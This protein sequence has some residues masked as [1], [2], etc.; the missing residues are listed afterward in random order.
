[1]E[2]PRRNLGADGNDK[3]RGEDRGADQ[4]AKVQGHR[5]SISTGFAQRRC[6][7]LDDPEP[8]RDG[9]NFAQSIFC[10]FTHAFFLQYSWRAP[11]S[12]RTRSMMTARTDSVHKPASAQ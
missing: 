4:I 1:M 9:W 10:D 7:Y 8:E 12:E 2:A 5:D 6:Q 3:D 11:W